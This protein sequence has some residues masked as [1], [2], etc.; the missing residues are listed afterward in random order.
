MKT[1]QPDPPPAT[2]KRRKYTKEMLPSNQA[3]PFTTSYRAETAPLT[4]ARAG[5]SVLRAKG[6]LACRG[7]G[8][9]RSL[10]PPS[11][12]AVVL[13]VKGAARRLRRGL[14]LPGRH[15]HSLRR[16]AQLTLGMDGSA[17]RMWV[18]SAPINALGTLIPHFRVGGGRMSSPLGFAAGDRCIEPGGYGRDLGW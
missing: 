4:P 15:L 16:G 8:S 13:G 9:S 14:T 7:S 17:G 6:P 11:S 12:L 5:P 2:R 3:P 10:R 18:R 1:Q